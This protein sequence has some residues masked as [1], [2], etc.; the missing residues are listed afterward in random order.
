MIII[1][2]WIYNSNVTSV[3]REGEKLCRPKKG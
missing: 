2:D 3:E 1:V